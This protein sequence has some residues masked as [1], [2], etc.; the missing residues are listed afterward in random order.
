MPLAV[1]LEG[2]AVS[3]VAWHFVQAVA[4]SIDVKFVEMSLLLFVQPSEDV[5]TAV[6]SVYNGVAFLPTGHC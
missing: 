1:D 6:L 3:L 2:D 4:V 5:V